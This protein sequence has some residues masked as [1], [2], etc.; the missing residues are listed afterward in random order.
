MK[1][2]CENIGKLS[3]AEVEINTLTLIA[4]LN[5]T[6]K[7]TVGKLLYCIFNSFYRF[8]ENAERTLK[9]FLKNLFLGALFPPKNC[10]DCI[11]ELYKLRFSQDR[12]LI[13]KTIHDFYSD[14]FPDNKFLRKKNEQL[15]DRIIE[16]LIDRIVE[17]LNLTDDEIYKRILQTKFMSEFGNQIQNIFSEKKKASVILS[18]KDND[19]S[20]AI[21]NDEIYG[22]KNF[23]NLQTEVIYI[24][25]PFVLD[26]L[27][28]HRSNIFTRRNHKVHLHKK[29][30]SNIINGTDMD[31]AIKE[32]LATK[33]LDAIYE[34]IDSVCNGNIVQETKDT[35]V[36]QYEKSKKRLDIV[37]LSTGLK[38][39]SIIKTL[40]MNGAL[41]Q[42]GVIILDEPEIHLHPAWQKLFAEIIVLLQVKFNMHILLN[43]HSPYFINAIDLYAKK[44]KIRETCKFYLTRDTDDT[45]TVSELVDVSD[46]IEEINKLLFTPLQEME[47]ERSEIEDAMSGENDD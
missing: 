34:L 3:S 13:K 47:D 38:T 36:F 26:N 24:D 21:R 15:I 11:E 44:Y 10:D 23:Q 39:F 28:T 37:N 35:F 20:V 9:R 18:I 16:Q 22:L 46:N 41:E 19:I 12:D 8:E 4:G 14:R 43:S 31:I 45:H 42:N 5:A 7:S 1:L 29:L 32:I 30:V 17:L 27:S 6:G 2:K 40:L 25:D 33:Q